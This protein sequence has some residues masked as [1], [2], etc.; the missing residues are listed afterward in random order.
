M[1]SKFYKFDASEIKGKSVEGIT[2]MKSCRHLS[3]RFVKM[4]CAYC[5]FEL[6]EAA[7]YVKKPRYTLALGG[8]RLIGKEVGPRNKGNQ[9]AW[10]VLRTSQDL[11]T[12]TVGDTGLSG[13]IHTLNLITNAS[14]LYYFT[15]TKN[16]FLSTLNLYT[17]DFESNPGYWPVH[18]PFVDSFR[19]PI[20]LLC[21][22]HDL[23][24]NLDPMFSLSIAI[25]EYF[26]PHIPPWFWWM[27]EHLI[28]LSISFGGHSTMH[29]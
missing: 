15:Y 20:I 9:R 27:A 6:F 13:T 16:K 7:H 24:L 22:L 14:S 5:V 11:T 3:P 28:L 23:C 4:S 12:Q 8:N 10:G 26:H 2:L 1:V 21:P 19:L 29:P 18:I 25:A 17:G